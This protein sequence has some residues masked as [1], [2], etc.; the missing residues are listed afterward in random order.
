MKIAVKSRGRPS[1]YARFGRIAKILILMVPRG[2][3]RPTFAAVHE[4]VD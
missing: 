1:V 2:G 3:T 4:R